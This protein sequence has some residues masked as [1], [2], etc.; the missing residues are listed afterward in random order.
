MLN[1]LGVLN[2]NVLNVL[3]VLNVVNAQGRIMAC[4]A[5]FIDA[6]IIYIE[7]N[8]IFL[9]SAVTGKKI[10][11]FA[12]NH[13][14]MNCPSSWSTITGSNFETEK[15]EYWVS[16]RLSGWVVT[17]QPIISWLKQ[18]WYRSQWPIW[19]N[20]YYFFSFIFSIIMSTLSCIRI[21]FIWKLTALEICWNI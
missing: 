2:V 1:E 19:Q 14:R 18:M 10:L 6:W 7:F 12:L 17:G 21:Y 20:N 4:W 16:D 3:N 9:N 13:T 11:A 5:L 15:G 8:S